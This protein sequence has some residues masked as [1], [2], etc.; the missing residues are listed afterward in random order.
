ML[1]RRHGPVRA[2][3]R[4]NRVRA[5]V[6]DQ[7]DRRELDF[8]RRA[9]SLETIRWSQLCNLAMPVANWLESHQLRRRTA[10]SRLRASVRSVLLAT[11]RRSVATGVAQSAVTGCTKTQPTATLRAS[12]R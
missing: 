6:G 9:R 10:T 12:G 3:G 7:L 2:W 5:Q 4:R 8:A 11:R 1:L